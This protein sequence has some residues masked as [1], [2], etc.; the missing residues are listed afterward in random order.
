MALTAALACLAMPAPAQNLSPYDVNA[1][2]SKPADARVPY[3]TDPLQFGD[4]RVP[5]GPGPFAVVVVIHGGCWLSI[6]NL[7][8]TAPM[9]DA[10]RDAGVA[11]WNVE[12]RPVDRQGGGWPGTFED[13]GAALDSV[14]A[15]AAKH[16][17]DPNRVVVAG[18]S[19]GAHLALWAAAR[20]RLKSDSPLHGD[21][22]L[23]VLAAVALGGPGDLRDFETYGHE[24]CGPAVE[25]L[26]G[27]A[28][29]AVPERW[30]QASPAELLPLGTRQVL[31]VGETDRVMPERAREAYVAKARAA[32]DT[33]E[34]VV[35]PG[36]HFEVIAPT[37]KAFATVKDQ[38]LGLL[39][40]GAAPA[41][42][43]GRH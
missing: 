32:G 5:Q 36:A 15:L 40:I 24:I 26:L 37:T 27:G 42:A 41:A 29:D 19:A 39:G 14:R 3:G 18:H 31:I 16:P 34:V 33:I 7:D 30:A 1:L 13:I 20:S 35:V 4:L 12:Y 25:Q 23:P 17:L 10:L 22:P 38:I 2:P 43:A 9:A 28:P 11:T 8:N 21:N 6:A